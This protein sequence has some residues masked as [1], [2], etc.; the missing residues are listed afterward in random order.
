D[1]P[2][3]A[4]VLAR[5]A[6]F[7]DPEPEADIGHELSLV[8]TKLRLTAVDDELRALFDS[9]AQSPDALRRSRELMDERRRLKT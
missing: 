3:A 7:H 4:A 2:G 5:I 6:D 1:D 8:V 9:G